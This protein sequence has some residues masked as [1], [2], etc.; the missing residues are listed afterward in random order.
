MIQ[1]FDIYR[2]WEDKTKLLLIHFY[3]SVIG[4]M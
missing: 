4:K 2:N 1:Y 3:G